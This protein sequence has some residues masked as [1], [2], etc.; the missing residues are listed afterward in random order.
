[1]GTFNRVYRLDIQLVMLVVSTPLVYC[2]P[3]TF[4]LAFSPL[5]LPTYSIVPHWNR[6]FFI[7]PCPRR[8]RQRG[9]RGE[10]QAKKN[11]EEGPGSACAGIT[12]VLALASP[13][14]LSPHTILPIRSGGG[15]TAESPL[16]PLHPS[17]VTAVSRGCSRSSQQPPDGGQK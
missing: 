6:R 8:V 5:P 2:C 7:D 17:P 1:L 16:S 14:S 11:K 15:G 4:S 9:K 13:P 12:C 10:D 3:T